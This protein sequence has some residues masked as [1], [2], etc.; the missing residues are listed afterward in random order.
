MKAFECRICGECCFGEGGIFVEEEEAERIA[1][2]LD[3][4]PGEF[5]SQFCEERNGRLY[6]RTGE[7]G[8]CLYYDKEKSCLIHP[9]KPDRCCLWPFF[10]A[11]V[12]DKDAWELAKEACPGINPDCSYE[13]FV[14]QAPKNRKP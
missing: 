5:T 12:H 13:E 4:A 14:R 9:V 7:D 2:F 3:V 8:F 10:P 1:A 6:I 11:N